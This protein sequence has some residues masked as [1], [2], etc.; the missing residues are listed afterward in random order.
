MSTA[1]GGMQGDATLPD[2]QEVVV[3]FASARKEGSY[4]AAYAQR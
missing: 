3:A 1:L 4:N 2:T